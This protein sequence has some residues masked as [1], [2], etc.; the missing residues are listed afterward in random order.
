V[1][2][3]S[4]TADRDANRAL[5]ERLADVYGRYDRLRSEL[6]EL[7]ERLSSMQVSAV[8]ADGLVQATVGPRGQLID[9]RLDHQACRSVDAD[10]LAQT[11]VATAR[12]AAER[13]AGEVTALMA[14]YLPPDSGTMHFLRDNDFA[15]LM[16]RPDSIVR[17][18]RPGDPADA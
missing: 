4:E 11:I 12:Q 5:R 2:T 1:T 15:S 10:D 14:G 16:R 8:S 17:S 18:S 3:V 9:L 13:T 7:R 6:D